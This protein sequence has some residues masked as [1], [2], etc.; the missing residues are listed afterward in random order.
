[1]AKPT[2][3]NGDLTIAVWN[4]EAEAWEQLAEPRIST[5]RYNFLI[6]CDY[7]DWSG[8]RTLAECYDQY[9]E[10]GKRQG[11]YRIVERL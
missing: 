6:M 5:D 4:N 3:L 11:F 8:F 7:G 2:I 10:R 9:M 1:M